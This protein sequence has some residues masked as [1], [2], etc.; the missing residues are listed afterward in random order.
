[1]FFDKFFVPTNDVL[2]HGIYKPLTTEPYITICGKQNPLNLLFF[3]CKKLINAFKTR[4]LKMHFH[5]LLLALPQ[6]FQVNGYC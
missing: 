5:C 1:M 4:W 3:Q 2:I 6:G